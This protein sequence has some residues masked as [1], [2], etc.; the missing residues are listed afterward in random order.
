MDQNPIQSRAAIK[1]AT[2]LLAIDF[3]LARLGLALSDERHL[4]ASPLATWPTAKKLEQTAHNLYDYLCE[5]Q[6][7]NS[8]T[9]TAIIV[10]MPLRMNGQV[11][12][13]A[14]EVQHFVALLRKFTDIPI[15]LWDERLS[16]MQAERALKE[17]Q[18]LNRKR[19]TAF[20]DQVAAVIL[21]QSY[22]DWLH[23]EQQ[24]QQNDETARKL[25]PPAG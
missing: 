17:G 18:H 5:Q 21:L 12:F 22:L 9:L 11:S 13:M 20:V 16:T 7:K 19:R 14:D 6:K 10:G 4:I 1:P 23:I 24:R 8:Y 25:E 2:R 3:G 15:T